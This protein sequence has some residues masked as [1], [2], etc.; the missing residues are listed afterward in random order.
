MRHVSVM[1]CRISS[2]SYPNLM[3]SQKSIELVKTWPKCMVKLP[4]ILFNQVFT[5]FGCARQN[6]TEKMEIIAGESMFA[7]NILCRKL[8]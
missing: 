3:I 8:H 1:E 5:Y 4:N 2:L 6:V 7:K